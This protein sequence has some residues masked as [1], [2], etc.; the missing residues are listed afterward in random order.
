[1]P[2]SFPVQPK[3]FDELEL[4]AEPELVCALEEI[5][6][7]D[8]ALLTEDTS[9]EE[10]RDEECMMFVQQDPHPWEQGDVV[11]RQ[12]SQDQYPSAMH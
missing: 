9:L 3:E 8:V 7:D 2:H 4:P 12:P 1:M 5:P 10:L 6:V 11:G